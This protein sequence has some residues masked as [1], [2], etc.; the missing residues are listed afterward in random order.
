MTIRAD[1]TTIVN[2]KDGATL[3][4]FP[5]GTQTYKFKDAMTISHQDYAS[6]HLHYDRTK[7]RIGTCM[8]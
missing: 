7:E 1:Q 8:G 3:I 6:V 2:Y 5:D 4:I